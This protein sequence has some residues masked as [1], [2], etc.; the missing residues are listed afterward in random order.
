MR[1]RVRERNNFLL[2]KLKKNLKYKFSWFTN[3]N[4]SL[5]CPAFCIDNFIF[6]NALWRLLISFYKIF[7]WIIC[8]GSFFLPRFYLQQ[9]GQDF[10]LYP[11]FL[12]SLWLTVHLWKGI[13]RCID[14]LFYERVH[15]LNITK[16]DF[17]NFTFSFMMFWP[18][19]RSSRE[20]RFYQKL[21]KKR[22]P[23]FV[24]L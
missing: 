1:T 4:K 23:P 7:S 13:Y 8:A 14:L 24:R 16:K 6:P 22:A 2:K 3:C 11:H 9:L 19:Y 15:S 10:G 20:T 5:N 12:N 21:L 18:V 17:K